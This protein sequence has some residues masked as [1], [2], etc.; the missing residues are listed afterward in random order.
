M[1]RLVAVLAA[2][3]LLAGCSDAQDPV[4]EPSGSPSASSSRTPS[5]PASSATPTRTASP[6]AGAAPGP[7]YSDWELG[8]H[9]LPR[10]AAGFGEIRPTP[11]ALRN[12][13]FPTKDL[14][15]PPADG[16]FHATIGPVTDAIRQRMGETWSPACPVALSGLRYLTVSFRGFDQKAHTGEPGAGGEGG[17]GRGLGLPGALRGGLPD[18]GDAAADDRRP[19]G[20]ADRRRQRHRRA[21]VPRDARRDEFGRRT[22]TGWRSTSTRSSTPT[23]RAMWCF[24]SAPRRTSTGAARSP[25]S[26]TRAT[27]SCASSPGSAGP[28][29]GRGV[30][31]KDYQHF[32]ATGR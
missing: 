25:A 24:P 21:G 8:V 2:A 4:A 1:R 30:S 10:T 26:S 6:T 3:V 7:A 27:W 9:V 15:P 23:A 16:R 19:R 32:S 20:G 29:A 14:L 22:P 31:L 5:P 17:A 13:L 18:R 12:R 28:G 11:K